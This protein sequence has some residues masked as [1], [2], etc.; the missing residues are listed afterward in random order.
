[1]AICII[2]IRVTLI[3]LIYLL[4]NLME[5]CMIHVQPQAVWLTVCCL[6]ASV[7]LCTP[8]IMFTKLGERRNMLTNK[9]TSY[10]YEV[11]EYSTLFGVFSISCFFAKSIYVCKSCSNIIKVSRLGSFRRKYVATLVIKPVILPSYCQPSV[12]FTFQERVK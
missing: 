5:C 7:L 2:L 1:M 10:C 4:F 9:T 11:H 12:S 3:N 8:L 6:L